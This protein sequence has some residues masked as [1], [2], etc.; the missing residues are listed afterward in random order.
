MP[1]SARN[2]RHFKGSKF[3][4]HTAK[5]GWEVPGCSLFRGVVPGAPETPR[6]FTL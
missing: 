2:T 3:M 1:A 4:Y 5:F 6:L